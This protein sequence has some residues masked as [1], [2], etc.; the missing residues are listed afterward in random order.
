M[1]DLSPC[2][3]E[4][5][6]QQ[7]LFGQSSDADAE[8]L[9]RH[10]LDCSRCVGVMRTLKD[11]GRLLESLRTGKVSTMVPQDEEVEQLVRRVGSA[12]MAA[13]C[14]ADQPTLVHAGTAWP[15]TEHEATSC[16]A[17]PQAPEE[18][19]RLGIYR[20][21][22]VLGAGGMGVVFAAE[23]TQLRRQV[24]VKVLKGSLAKEPVHRERFLRE[25][26]AAA[27]LAHDHIITVHH[28]GEENGVPYLVMPL[29]QG[30]SLQARLTRP[31]R[32]PLPEVL[33]IGREMAEGLAVAHEHGLIH[34]D[35]KPDNVWLEAGTGRVKILDFGL[36]HAEKIDERLTQKGTIV[37]TPSFMAP[38][39]AR[40]T[41][42]DARCDLYSLGVVL[43]YLCT[44]RLPFPQKEL[45]TLLAAVALDPPPPVREINPDVPPALA[46]LIMQLL[47][48]Q[49]AERPASARAVVEA[50]RAIERG[51]APRPVR[52][53]RWPLVAAVVLL[54]LLGLAAWWF[55]PTVY[56]IATNKGEL[57]VTTDDS[58]VKVT[59]KKDGQEV[60]ILD[61]KTKQQ[62]VLDAGSYTI[63]LGGGANGLRL[64]TDHFTLTRGGR[65]IVKVERVGP[66]ARNG[67]GENKIGEIR[68]LKGHTHV[69]SSVALDAAAERAVS[70]GW[71]GKVLLWDVAT[72]EQ[73]GGFEGDKTVRGVAISPDGKRVAA[74]GGDKVVRLWDG[75]A[76]KKLHPLHTHHDHW[77]LVSGVAFAKEGRLLFSASHDGTVRGWSTGG[78]GRQVIFLHDDAGPLG[79]MDCL[80]VSPDG[81]LLLCGGQDKVV[82][83]WDLEKQEHAGAFKG[84]T[85]PVTGVAFAGNGQV[86]ASGSGD[87]TVRIWKLP[88]GEALHQLTLP[89]AVQSV[90]LAR[91]GKRALAGCRDGTVRLWDVGGERELHCFKGH[92]G[93]VWSVALS[94]DG[95]LALSGGEDNTVRLWALPPAE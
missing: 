83:L 79:K 29:L 3:N 48:K 68:V 26:R 60:E 69:V 24:A 21:L 51:A 20:V 11:E 86:V 65:E 66:A 85:E 92:K 56:R 63:E 46:D 37:G 4:Q 80:A 75:V 95:R 1:A 8:R 91:D 13:A 7:L 28:V 50:L 18:I 35:V 93:R 59:V 94:T 30:E 6:L 41:T 47:A 33:R 88:G 25:A 57:V 9:E 87:G 16:L 61:L 43:Y 19:G 67:A 55:G 23:D 44:G 58:D 71:D 53:R 78:A 5:D 72:G 84:H 89:A 32:V 42:V 73:L 52:K 10:L 76:D 90:A 12:T 70:G 77:D 27:A 74:A 15:A 40:G 82:H 38:E 64:T 14:Q 39:Q 49:P 62:V 31:E 54:C 2:P 22:R 36:A 34:R 17:P 45:I 81:R